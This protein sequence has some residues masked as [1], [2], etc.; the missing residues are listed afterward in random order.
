MKKWPSKKTIILI[1]IIVIVVLL[2]VMGAFIGIAKET[3]L[4]I[5]TNDLAEMKT[6]AHKYLN[7]KNRYQSANPEHNPNT[8]GAPAISDSEMSSELAKRLTEDIEELV[9]CPCFDDFATFLRVF[10]IRREGKEVVVF[11]K[12]ATIYTYAPAYKDAGIYTGEGMDYYFKFARV[13]GRW[14]MQDARMLYP[15]SECTLEEKDV[16]E[17]KMLVNP[18]L[19][20]LELRSKTVSDISY[21]PEN[22][23]KLDEVATRNITN[24]W[25][26]DYAAIEAMASSIK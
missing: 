8:V 13:G 14:I 22:I 26:V 9:S 11:M 5:S 1:P 4:D 24:K 6:L 10:D 3:K 18:P 19:D 17:I 16:A 12:E 15:R 20:P 23:V 25:A 21:I 2:V 7:T